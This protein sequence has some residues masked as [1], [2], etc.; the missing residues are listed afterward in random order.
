MGKIG[1]VIN[2]ASGTLSPEEAKKRLEE[3]KEQLGSIVSPEC[4]SVVSGDQI[5]QEIERLKKQGIDTLIAGGGDGTIS[6]AAELVADTPITLVVAALGTRNHFA[7]DL[8]IPDDPVEAI[9]LV[10]K[11]NV[12]QVDLGEVN[13]HVFINN[14]TIGL[15]PEI[16]EKREETMKRGWKKGAAHIAAAL[17][18]LWWMP[19]MRLSVKSE[20]QQ[21]YQLIP[22]LFVGNNEYEGKVITD[23]K[24]SSLNE[25]KLWLCKPR[26]P[27]KWPLLQMS[28]QLVLGGFRGAENLE[29]HLVNSLSVDSRKHIVKVAI[30]GENHNLASPLQ[31]TVRRKNLRVVV[32]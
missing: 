6:A 14:A 13:G 11:M 1:A 17:K 18:V 31:F 27:G 16:V 8:G 29:T 24:R 30:D 9:R 4:L 32:P 23:S 28:W 26:M 25:G 20:K 7:R 10:H 3:V 15:Y 12:K 21:D 22:F 2:K 19:H 5:K